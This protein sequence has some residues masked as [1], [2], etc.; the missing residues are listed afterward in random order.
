MQVTEIKKRMELP[1]IMAPMFLI[2][3]PT[4]VVS[5]CEAG[6][7]GTFPALNARTTEILDSWMAEINERLAE[8]TESDPNA[9]VAPWGVN[10]ISHSSNKRFLE[11]LELIE[12]HQPPIVITSLGDP[13]PVV[14]V[15]HAYGGLVLSDVIDVK[16]AKKALEKGSD[17]LIL[18][19]SGAG[20]HAG[21]LNPFAFVDEVRSFFDGPLALAGTITKGEQIAAAELLGADFSYIG[22]HFIATKESGASEAYQDTIIRSAAADIIYTPAF[23]GIPANYLI[24]SI[25]KAGL[26]P[27]NLPKKAGLDFKKLS[28]SSAKAWK[29]IW[30]AGQ[31][32]GGTMKSQ[33]VQDAVNELKTAYNRAKNI[34]QLT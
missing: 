13:S 18:V 23:S 2:S 9:K 15:V 8:K 14:K 30:G 12:K 19:A 34:H 24:P 31:G 7:I 10:F 4:M 27:E 32:V 11:D 25:V 3:N 16:F 17:G 20:G 22:T 1:V 26:D 29:D 6:I 21:T 33:S 28:D 5:A